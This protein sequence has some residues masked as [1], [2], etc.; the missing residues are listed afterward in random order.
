MVVRMLARRERIDTERDDPKRI[1]AIMEEWGM[2]VRLMERSG[3]INSRQ[4]LPCA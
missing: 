2:V 4:S 1:E 3:E